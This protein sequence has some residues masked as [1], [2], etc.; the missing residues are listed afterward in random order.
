MIGNASFQFGNKSY[1]M[2]VSLN[3]DGLQAAM[4]KRAIALNPKVI[5]LTMHR[6]FGFKE[7]LKTELGRMYVL[8]YRLGNPNSVLPP[9]TYKCNSTT[10]LFLTTPPHPSV[11]LPPPTA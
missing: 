2:S 7:S 8:G 4:T 6:I 1:A 3:R 10:A 5:S 11:P 9:A